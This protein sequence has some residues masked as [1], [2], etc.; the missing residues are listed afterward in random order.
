L[1]FSVNNQSILLSFISYEDD[2]SID[3]GCELVKNLMYKSDY[4]DDVLIEKFQA[5]LITSEEE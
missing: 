1:V 2:L 3:T 4:Y 5:Q